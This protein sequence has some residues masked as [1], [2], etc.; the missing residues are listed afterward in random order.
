MGDTGP[1]KNDTLFG[2][3]VEAWRDPQIRFAAEMGGAQSLDQTIPDSRLID[4]QPRLRRVALHLFA[5]VRNV[6][7][8]VFTVLLDLRSP[9][10]A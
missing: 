1:E 6:N 5:E 2:G 4:D 10:L 7:A 3:E 8:H 9:D